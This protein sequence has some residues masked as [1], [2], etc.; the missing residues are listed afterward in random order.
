[1]GKTK[2]SMKTYDEK[3]CCGLG[4]GL[5]DAYDRVKWRDG[6]KLWKKVS[7]V[8]EKGKILTITK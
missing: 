6:V 4:L 1:M 8:L 3:L 5:E 2:V 7:E